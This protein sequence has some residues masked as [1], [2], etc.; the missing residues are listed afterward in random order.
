ME[1]Q[2]IEG[3]QLQECCVEWQLIEGL[4]L[5]GALIV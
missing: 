1:W 4:Q 2:L 5:Q 3:L